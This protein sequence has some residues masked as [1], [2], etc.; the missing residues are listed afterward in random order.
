MKRTFW[1]AAM[2]HPVESAP[3][4]RAARIQQGGDEAQSA[5]ADRMTF[6]E[7][8]NNCLQNRAYTLYKI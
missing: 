5:A 6:Y 7:A 3:P 8:V 2:I 4:S 1:Y